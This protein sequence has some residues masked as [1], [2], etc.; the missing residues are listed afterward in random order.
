[1]SVRFVKPERQSGSHK[2]QN[3]KVFVVGGS[4]NYV[5]APLLAS[6][7]AM[8]TGCDNVTVAAPEKVAWAINAH[9]PDLITK[10]LSGNFLDASHAMHISMIA[11]GFDVLLF[12]NGLGTLPGTFHLCKQLAGLPLCKVIDADGI[13]ALALH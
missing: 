3:G 7:A 8:H 11:E 12:G 4:E 2:G 9:S 6:L 10:K 5:G 13:K 1:M